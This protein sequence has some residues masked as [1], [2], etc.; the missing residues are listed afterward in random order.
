MV[1]HFSHCQLK[2][3]CMLKTN[4]H[5]YTVK[6]YNTQPDS[7]T[8]EDSSFFST[9]EVFA[10]CKVINDRICGP[11]HS[12]KDLHLSHQSVLSSLSKICMA[13]VMPQFISLV[14]IAR[15]AWD[16]EPLL[17]RTHERKKKRLH[18]QNLTT[19]ASEAVKLNNDFREC[20][21]A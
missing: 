9:T 8:I 12:R 7:L 10:C 17:A 2:I 19:K 14:S 16:P 3:N 18:F 4:T 1:R 15:K 11:T 6:V 5:L 20:T 21:S 13:P